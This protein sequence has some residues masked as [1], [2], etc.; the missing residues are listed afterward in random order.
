[1]NDTKREALCQALNYHSHAVAH[2]H[3]AGSK[4]SPKMASA[5]QVVATAAKFVKF[6]DGMVKR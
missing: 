1:M 5:E 3:V 4:T 2:S 6:L